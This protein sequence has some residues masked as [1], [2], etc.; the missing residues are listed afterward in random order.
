MSCINASRLLLLVVQNNL[1]GNAWYIRR[2]TWVPG[3][4]ITAHLRPSVHESARDRANTRRR[5]DA[6]LT[7]DHRT[8]PDAQINLYKCDLLL[9]LAL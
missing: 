9:A 1:R 6:I 2:S 4:A 7:R 3:H 5:R 8:Y